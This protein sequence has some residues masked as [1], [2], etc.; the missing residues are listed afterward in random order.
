M[1]SVVVY[2][3]HRG[4]VR[5][6]TQNPLTQTGMRSPKGNSRGLPVTEEPNRE[7][8]QFNLKKYQKP[9]DKIQKCAIMNTE[10]EVKKM[11]IEKLK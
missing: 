3:N 5:T 1:R 6:S 9:I 10:S 11:P 4:E 7:A 8:P 2:Y